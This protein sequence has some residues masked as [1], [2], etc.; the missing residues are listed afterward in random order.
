METL[1]TVSY[2]RPDEVSSILQTW[3]SARDTLKSY[4]NRSW[5]TVDC[6]KRNIVDKK[7]QICLFPAPVYTAIPSYVWEL[8]GS[9]HMTQTEKY[10]TQDYPVKA[11]A[12]NDIYECQIG[13]CHYIIMQYHR[14]INIHRI[15][16]QN[17]WQ[18]QK[19]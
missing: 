13:N 18:P 7:K 2:P 11:T 15:V 6:G 8:A 16:S 9:S 5:N 14:V 12:S 1:H 17:S 4:N 19:D 10:T 3:A